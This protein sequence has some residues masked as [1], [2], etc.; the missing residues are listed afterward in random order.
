MKKDIVCILSVLLVILCIGVARSTSVLTVTDNV[1]F[2]LE[3]IDEDGYAE[4]ADSAHVHVSHD[5]VGDNA[6]TYSARTDD[7]TAVWV[8]EVT[9]AGGKK[10]YQF[11]DVAGDLDDGQG[12]GLYSM[13]VYLFA[14]GQRF[15][16]KHDFY[17]AA[18]NTNTAQDETAAIKAK[19]DN[20]PTD[21]ADA[22]VI[23]DKLGNMGLADSSHVG[24]EA[25]AI[26]LDNA[27][28]TLANSQIDDDVDVDVHT[29]DGTA[30]A[31][32][33]NGWVTATTVDATSISGSS[34]AADNMELIYNAD[35][36]DRGKVHLSQ[37]DIVAS[38][39]D[40]AIYAIGSG[41]GEGMKLQGGVTGSGM[42][43]KGGATSG[44]G[45]WAEATD[46]SNGTG[47]Y[48]KGC[49]S[50]SGFRG[51]GGVG[52]GQTGDGMELM[53][54]ASGK[55]FR[56]TL[57][58]DDVSGD[59]AFGTEIDTAGLSVGSGSALRL[60]IYGRIDTVACTL[61]V[62]APHGDD[63]GQAGTGLD[64][65]GI[66]VVIANAINDSNIARDVTKTDYQSSAG[67][68]A[69]PVRILLASTEDT[70]S[71][72]GGT[73]G[74]YLSD[75]T[76]KHVAT[77]GS[78]GWANMTLLTGERYIYTTMTGYTIT[79]PACTLTVPSDSLR[80]TV[81]ATP[82]SFAGSDS[83][84]ITTVAGYVRAMGETIEGANVTFTLAHDGPLEYGNAIYIPLPLK[85]QTNSVGRFSID[86]PYSA[87]TTAL[88]DSVF[89]NVEITWGDKKI[90]NNYE[91]YGGVR[92]PDSTVVYLDDLD[93]W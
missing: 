78:D 22:S 80:D 93:G 13:V 59:L 72:Q 68:G 82:H 73:I 92:V 71:L 81:W 38:G 2:F 15:P 6:I 46:G 1:V 12:D 58:L 49:G 44:I 66:D 16:T 48:A 29:W 28:G 33:D 43:T 35:S 37:L 69:I 54:G 36:T 70:S 18:T 87:F 65:A 85:A 20:L 42:H 9:Y 75:G 7:M 31:T 30:A 32:A 47:I 39:D 56:V 76:K 25:A 14:D 60:Q 67:P 52:G 26:N 23:A 4:D 55:D 53:G 83:V 10:V 3:G 77:T 41:T 64:S 11:R 90:T 61:L 17:L 19:T 8:T 91:L 27:T 88:G 57:N 21:P 74:V 24:T 62:H 34:A 50:G 5:G 63:W 45:I 40:N 84:G 79:T 89:Y 86:V 51:L